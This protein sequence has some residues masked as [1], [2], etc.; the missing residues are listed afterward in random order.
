MSNNHPEI[1]I[2]ALIHNQK[3]NLCK[4][5]FIEYHHKEPELLT[6]SIN[7]FI[8]LNSIFDALYAEFLCSGDK[9]K[10]QIVDSL[11]IEYQINLG[12]KSVE[13]II[14][15]GLSVKLD[16]NHQ[17]LAA[18]EIYKTPKSFKIITDLLSINKLA[19]LCDH[20]SASFDCHNDS[21]EA[22]SIEIQIPCA[23]DKSRLQFKPLNRKLNH[24]HK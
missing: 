20:N 12:K 5:I 10:K 16:K 24:P 6:N 8:R 2:F 3:Q 21:N 1:E 19:K 15:E 13:E 9:I 4:K 7:S 22:W 11:L 18:N 14:I 17:T 23:P